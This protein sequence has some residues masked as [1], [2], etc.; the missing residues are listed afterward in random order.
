MKQISLLLLTF[1]IISCA[2]EADLPLETTVPQSALES[3]IS[4]SGLDGQLGPNPMIILNGSLKNMA[5]LVQEGF[6]LGK[7]GENTIG[8]IDQ[9]N[10]ELLHMFGEAASDGLVIIRTPQPKGDNQS[11]KRQLSARTLLLVNGIPTNF[12]ELDSLFPNKIASVQVT[13]N[14]SILPV[15]SNMGYEGIVQIQ[16]K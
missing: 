3:Y 1:C 12:E 14:S 16:T 15:L 9:G 6:I 11:P 2:N 10:E 4:A 7:N 13:K 8:I 5:E